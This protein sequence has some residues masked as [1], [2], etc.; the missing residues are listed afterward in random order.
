MINKFGAINFP[1]HNLFLGKDNIGYR[2]F[3]SYK[4]RNKNTLSENVLY[5]KIADAPKGD[6][7][8]VLIHKELL[9]SL[10][11]LLRK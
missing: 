4:R 7:L 1:V 11:Y 10:E 5:D 9:N 2:E 3:Q 8:A 6:D